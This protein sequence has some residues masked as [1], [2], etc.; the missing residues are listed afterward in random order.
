MSEVDLV[1]NVVELRAPSGPDV[2]I[3]LICFN[4]ARRVGRAMRSLV[5]Q[6]LRN[7]EIIVVDDASTDDTEQVVSAAME[8]DSRIRYIRL[9]ENSGGCSAPRNRLDH[10]LRLG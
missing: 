10:V 1:G 7:I 3:V 9:A 2:S 6:T 4:D 8:T 5:N